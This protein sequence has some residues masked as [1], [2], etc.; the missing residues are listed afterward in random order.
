M[1]EFTAALVATVREACVRRSGTDAVAACADGGWNAE[2]WAAL[3]QIGV[4]T[5]SV[6]EELGGAGGDVAATVAVLEVLGEYSAGVP[7][8]ETALLAGRLIAD[9][10]GTV[11]SGPM[12]AAVTGPELRTR[13]EDAGLSVQGTL[14]RVPWAR[15]AHHVAVLDN[16]RV[17][18]LGRG[19]FLL[20]QG[21]NLAGEPRDDLEVDAVLPASQVYE[22]PA[23]SPISA[24]ALRSRAA[25]ARAAL[26]VGAG[27]QALELAVAYAGEREQ[28]GRPIAKF[29]A[30]Q[31]H[32][33][34]MAGEV[35]LAKGAVEAAALAVDT[36]GDAD[37]AVAA[38]KVV[39]GQMA[40]VVASL[41]HQIHGAI[42]YT[43]EHSLRHSTTR[44]WAWRD[45]SGNED[46]WSE[47]LGRR[48]LSAGTGGLWPLLTGTR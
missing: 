9:C 47:V 39:A 8:A 5:L 36:Q 33:A 19:D 7:L 23:D 16:G 18:L 45:E 12:T 14:A 44:L 28:F 35:L 22:P 40:G 29:Q 4:T 37:V 34:A 17:L 3:E 20:R 26:M 6:P 30:V 31:Q 48:A 27:R 41:A 46:E 2:L 15:N 42:G 11:P 43:E 25:L 24:R 10:G 32:L 21:T 38:A 13:R 1:S